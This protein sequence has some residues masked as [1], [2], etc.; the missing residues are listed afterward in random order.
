MSGHQTSLIN[1]TPHLHPFQDDKQWFERTRV[2]KKTA[3]RTIS[4]GMQSISKVLRITSRQSEPVGD[5]RQRFIVGG[6]SVLS[7]RLSHKSCVTLCHMSHSQP[8]HRVSRMIRKNHVTQQPCELHGEPY[9]IRKNRRM[10]QCRL[11]HKP[12][13]HLWN[14]RMC[15][16][17]GCRGNRMTAELH[18]MGSRVRTELNR[19]I[20]KIR[21]N[22]Y[23]PLQSQS[24]RQHPAPEEQ[25]Y[26]IPSSLPTSRLLNCSDN[27][28]LSSTLQRERHAT[29]DESL[30]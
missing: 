30:G 3:F 26:P 7:D 17:H 8:E 5:L 2:S 12:E 27:E 6:L 16:T 28:L 13:H 20:R 4:Y 29:R 23:Q 19:M 9:E 10:R 14:H 1:P 25:N 11:N 18:K 24:E 15:K 21:V 22:A